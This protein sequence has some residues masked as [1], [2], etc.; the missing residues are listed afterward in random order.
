M[1]F[2]ADLYVQIVES[3]RSGGAAGGSRDQRKKPRVGVN[4]RT[5]ILIPSK[6]GAKPIPVTVRDLSAEGAGLLLAEP[7]L[8]S[9]EEF[10]LVLAQ[11]E[12]QSKRLIVYQA[13]RVTRLS[14]ALYQ[15]GAQMIR[16]VEGDPLA[17]A[18]PRASAI[19]PAPK[20]PTPQGTPGPASPVSTAQA[21][22]SRVVRA[23]EPTPRSPTSTVQTEPRIQFTS[24]TDPVPEADL[25]AVRA[26]EARLRDLVA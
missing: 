13:R 25:D 23:A 22:S 4:A 8:A 17:D 21:Q 12:R 14:Q 2:T 15:V 6:T 24:P 1:Q 11:G 19:A 26:V 18:R 5:S 16:E 7:V 9:G 3:L 10:I 20:P